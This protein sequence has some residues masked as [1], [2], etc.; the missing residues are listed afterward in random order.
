[1]PVFTYGD[2]RNI[3]AGSEI[4]YITGNSTAT[5]A[6]G[7]AIQLIKEASDVNMDNNEF[8]QLQQGNLAPIANR[9]ARDLQGAQVIFL[10]VSYSGYSNQVVN[11]R[12]YNLRI[13][14]I[15]LNRSA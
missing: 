15:V 7:Q 13:N 6:P 11:K 3:P 8:A 1:M 12:V 9:I 5:I 10:S 14:A 4:Q 2:L